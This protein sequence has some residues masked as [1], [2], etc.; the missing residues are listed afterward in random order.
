MSPT[1]G[2]A[3][4]PSDYV[5]PTGVNLLDEDQI[6]TQFTGNTLTGKTNG[7]DWWEYYSSNGTL[8]GDG[9]GF[10]KYSADWEVAGPV[11][12]W[13]Y[14]GKKFDGCFTVSVQ[15]GVVQFYTLDGEKFRSTRRL[16]PGNPQGL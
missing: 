15:E 13:D 12:C 3:G 10:K 14:P 11:M 6:K 5:T 9:E 2:H 8:R 7:N 4:V 1:I 16:L